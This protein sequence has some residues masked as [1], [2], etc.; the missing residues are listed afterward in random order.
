VARALLRLR[1]F[2][3]RIFRFE[4]EPKDTLAASFGSRLTLEDRA[5]SFVVPG[6]PEG[7]FRVV[8]RFENEQLLEIQ[9]RTVHGRPSVPWLKRPMAIDLTGNS[10][11]ISMPILLRKA[12]LDYCHILKHS[13]YPPV[14][15]DEVGCAA[16]RWAVSPIAAE[17]A[18]LH[19][20]FISKWH[21]LFYHLTVEIGREQMCGVECCKDSI[22]LTAINSGER[23][24]TLMGA[25]IMVPNGRKIVYFG[26]PHV[27][28]FPHHL[29]AGQSFGVRMSVES[30]GRSLEEAHFARSAHLV[31][32]FEDARDRSYRSRR[33][34]L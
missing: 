20:A 29:V 28:D 23:S 11:V 5:H 21:G 22:I 25:G 17:I 24:M 32:Y 12:T 8:Y 10:E 4:A 18:G 9:N 26:D 31:G 16:S 13:P 6:M 34:R 3:G 14:S 33:F 27:F 7:L 19:S 2:L 1:F 15:G 30:V